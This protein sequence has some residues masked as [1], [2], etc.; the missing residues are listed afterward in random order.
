MSCP[1]PASA[2]HGYLRTGAG[3]T[4]LIVGA[5]SAAS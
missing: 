5:V 4:G 2:L 3:Q 1:T